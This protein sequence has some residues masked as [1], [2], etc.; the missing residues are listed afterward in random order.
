LQ[1]LVDGETATDTFTYTIRDAAGLTSNLVTAT[2]V[3]SG[4]NDNPVAVNDSFSVPFGISELLNVLANDKDPD[5]TIDPRTVEI[6]Q[7]AAHG[8]AVALSTGRIEYRPAAGY[9]GPDSFTYRVRDAFGA[10]SNEAIVTIVVN[11]APVAVSDAV[12]TTINTAVVI[13]VL[14]N[15]A[16]PDGTLNRTSVSIASGPDVGSATVNSDGTI[17]Y[18]PPAD[19]IG[20]ASLQ[21]AVLDNEGL[22]SNL[23]T[24]TIRVTGSIH[25]NPTNRLDVNN[26]GFVSPIDVLIVVND[27]NFNGTRVLPSTLPVPPYLDV[28]GDRSV[29]PLDVLELINFI[30]QRGGAGAGEGEGSLASLGYSQQNV[31]MVPEEEIIRASAEIEVQTEMIRQLDLAVASVVNDS[32]V[33]GPSLPSVSDESDEEEE[34]LESYLASWVTTKNKK[35]GEAIDSVFTDESWL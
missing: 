33:Y 24:V 4:V 10:I 1:R 34:S 5:S 17:R 25:Q 26:D 14:R 30:N 19:F 20:T 16:D 31:L 23:A 12:L 28:N 6:G 29:S 13:D 27:L 8:T 7:L 15:D 11:T 22:S 35:S 18:V 32:V 3:V 9:R 2:I 21:Y